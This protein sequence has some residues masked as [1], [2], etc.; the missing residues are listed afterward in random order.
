MSH[1]VFFFLE[2]KM[3]YTDSIN[4]S[5]MPKDIQSRIFVNHKSRFL[6]FRV[7]DFPTENLRIYSREDK[8]SIWWGEGTDHAR[9]ESI[10]FFI[11]LLTSYL[12][13]FF[14]FLRVNRHALLTSIHV[15]FFH[16]LLSRTMEEKK[17][18]IAIYVW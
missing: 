3:I 10:C 12:R 15:F 8:S 7:L 18:I 16:T 1:W 4:N 2:K 6:D 11:F 9:E 13:V 5:A 17:R 14:S